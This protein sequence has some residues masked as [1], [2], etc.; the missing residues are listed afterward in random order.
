MPP[1][2]STSLRDGPRGAAGGE[3]IVD[4]QDPRTRRRWRRDGLR[5]CRCRIRGRRRSGAIG[6]QFL[7]LADGHEPRAERISERGRENEAARFDPDHHI[8]RRALVLGLERVDGSLKSCFI[9]EKRGD[10]VEKDS[11]FGEVRNFADELFESV[12]K[13]LC[14]TGLKR[15]QLLH[16][17]FVLF[18]SAYVGRAGSLVQPGGEAVQLVRRA[19]GVNLHPAVVFIANPAGKA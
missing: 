16:G 3:Q 12:Q 17:G 4:N 5:A 14:L 15:T 1:S 13:S 18:N 7:R 8:D 11:G 10:V 2:C 6:G 9:F 19:D